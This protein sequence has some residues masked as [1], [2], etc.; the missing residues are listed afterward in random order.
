MK[1]KILSLTK[2]DF[3][4]Q[5]FKG[6]GA[7][8]QKKNKTSSACRCIH[9]PSNAIGTSQEERSQH[10]NRQI[11][12]RRCVESSVFQNWIKLQAAAMSK[13]F[14]DAER[15]VDDMMQEKYLKVETYIP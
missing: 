11:A 2:D 9:P 6:T 8:G 15:M 13:G 7:G 1:Q 5:Y 14:A 4:W 3:E 12:F 10:Q